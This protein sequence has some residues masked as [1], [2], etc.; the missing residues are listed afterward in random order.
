MDAKALA[1]S[2]RAHSLH[3]KKKHHTHQGLKVPSVGSDDK[4]G[5][6]KKASER[7]EKPHGQQTKERTPQYQGSRALMSNW[8]R[9]D[10]DFDL[11]S[12]NAQASSSQPTDF[13][14]PKS[15][16]ADYAHLISEAESQSQSHYSSDVL[17]LCDDFISDLMQDFGPMLA[18]KGQSILSWITDDSFEFEDKASIS[19]QAPFLSL[20]LDALAEQ[21][22]KAKLSERLYLQSDLLPLDLLDE[23]HD[24]DKHDP[25]TSI[26]AAETNT[27]FSSQSKDQAVT[28]TGDLVKKNTDE[29]LQ[30]RATNRSNLLKPV[31]EHPIDSSSG[32]F[33]AASAEAEL[34]MLLNSF[35]DTAIIREP[36][37]TGIPSTGD[38][39]VKKGV[40]MLNPTIIDDDVD[41]L[42]EET[43]SL[44]IAD[45]QMSKANT[46]S[47][48]SSKKPISKSEI[49]DDFD[50][51]LDT[52]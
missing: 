16:G 22:A 44:T 28:A 47:I 32:T 17:P 1:K 33:E 39:S 46:A 51:W 21:L 50:S 9:Y 36:S 30:P 40:T 19:P 24:E 38:V 6:E 14:M 5:V 4:K 29:I 31:S 42:L 20:N 48:S 49:V 18:A 37:L 7:P 13:V 23:A 43:S 41:I 11:A 10:E 52:I 3:H 2:K 34:D 15:L 25:E 27:L 12:E 26:L 45:Q 35:S 8:D